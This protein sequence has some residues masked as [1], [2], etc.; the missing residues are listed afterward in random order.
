MGP[1]DDENLPDTPED[2]ADP[3]SFNYLGLLLDRGMTEIV[4]ILRTPIPRNG[5]VY[6][7][8]PESKQWIDAAWNFPEAYGYKRYECTKL[9]REEAEREMAENTRL[10]ELTPDAIALLA[11]R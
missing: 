6:R 2:T 5:I 8:Q 7:W 9:T 1:I 3:D 10:F 4:A 11:K